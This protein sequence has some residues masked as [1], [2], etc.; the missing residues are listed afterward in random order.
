MKKVFITYSLF[1]FCLVFCV[2]INAD[3]QTTTTPTVTPGPDTNGT[4]TEAVNAIFDILLAFHV[5]VPDWVKAA[6]PTV[7]VWVFAYFKRK[8]LKED[9][10]KQ[11]KAVI[12]TPTGPNNTPMHPEHTN[13]L[14]NLIHKL[15]GKKQTKNVKP[16]N[17]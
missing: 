8:K 15:E 13:A 10:T 17:S 12:G 3:A 2:F 7:A 9:T 16:G 14:F 11:I 4:I 5:A 1:I 6:V